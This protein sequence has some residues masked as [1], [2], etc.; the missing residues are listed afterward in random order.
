MP[1]VWRIPDSPARQTPRSTGSQR[2]RFTLFE[3]NDIPWHRLH[4]GHPDDFAVP[5]DPRLLRYPTFADY[6]LTEG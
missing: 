5:Q 6:A 4:R 3:M 1:G 2:G